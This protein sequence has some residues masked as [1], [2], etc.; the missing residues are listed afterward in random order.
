MS[1]S[2][3]SVR[4]QL[5]VGRLNRPF[6]ENC[7]HFIGERVSVVLSLAHLTSEAM[8]QGLSRPLATRQSRTLTCMD[9]DYCFGSDDYYNKVRIEQRTQVYS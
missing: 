2:I 1:A 3:I 9:E 8:E 4:G 7:P 6:M 5:T